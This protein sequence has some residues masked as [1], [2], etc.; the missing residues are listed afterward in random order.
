MNAIQAAEMLN[1]TAQ[2]TN[3]E[4]Q[5]VGG[6]L[7]IPDDYPNVPIGFVEDIDLQ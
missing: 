6:I 2:G 4:M 3:Q 1:G 7:T 5:P